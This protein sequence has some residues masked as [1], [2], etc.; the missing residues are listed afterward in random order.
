[1][2]EPV[3]LESLLRLF[4]FDKK[5]ELEKYC[6]NAVVHKRDFATLVMA[7]KS[8]ILPFSHQIHYKDHVPSQLIPSEKERTA[9]Q[10]NG[11]G[12]LKGDAKK[13]VRKIGQLFKDRRYLVGHIFYT[14][15]LHEWHFFYFDQRDTEEQKENH[16]SGGS[17]IHFINWLWPNHSP[18]E[19]WSNFV[20]QSDPPKGA[21]HIKFVSKASDLKK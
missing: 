13:M 2:F 19:L 20:S 4:T 11:V 16:W 3:D 21:V 8:G 10:A 6:R 5:R 14:P 12:P 15:N 1:M 18:A 9:L 7:C 17:H